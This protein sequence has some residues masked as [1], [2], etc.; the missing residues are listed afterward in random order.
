[1]NAHVDRIRETIR[2]RAALFCCDNMDMLGKL[3]TVETAMLIG[4]SIVLETSI[5]L[6]DNPP[7][8]ES[9]PEGE[10]LLRQ[11]FE[12]E[13][14]HV[15]E[16]PVGVGKTQHPSIPMPCCERAETRTPH[17]FTPKE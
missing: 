6:E 15:N 16:V 1:M 11:L 17:C 13:A 8:L 9:T 3:H 7:P 4:A 14:L 5:D 12:S 2:Q 10:E